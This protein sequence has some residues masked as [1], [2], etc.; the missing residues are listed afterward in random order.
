MTNI[1]IDGPMEAVLSKHPIVPGT[2]FRPISTP[3]GLR[4]LTR[5]FMSHFPLWCLGTLTFPGTCFWMWW[6]VLIVDI[7]WNPFF[8]FKFVN[9]KV[10]FLEG[11]TKIKY[12]CHTGERLKIFFTFLF[13][14]ELLHFL[15]PLPASRASHFLA[16]SQINK[17]LSIIIVSIYTHMCICVNVYKYA[18]IIYNLLSLCMCVYTHSCMY[19]YGFMDDRFVLDSQ[20]RVHAWEKAIIPFPVIVSCLIFFLVVLIVHYVCVCVWVYV[21]A[22]RDHGREAH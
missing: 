7:S 2:A 18:Q 12:F 6:W 13:K 11:E 19:M 20:S 21:C 9:H 8:F 14:I 17:R 16:P 15:L 22:L 1:Q 5:G 10:Y 3:S 4:S